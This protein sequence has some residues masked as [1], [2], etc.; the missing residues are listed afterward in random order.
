MKCTLFLNSRKYIILITMQNLFKKLDLFGI[1]LHLIIDQDTTFQSI[2]GAILSVCVYTLSFVYFVYVMVL[3]GNGD[4]IPR[5]IQ[6][7]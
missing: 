1:N 6:N 3:W 5:L 2:V 7:E 4:I